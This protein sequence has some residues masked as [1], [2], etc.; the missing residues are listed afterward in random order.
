MEYTEDTIIYF[1]KHKKKKIKDIPQD[2]L[3]GLWSAREALSDKCMVAYLRKIFDENIDPDAPYTPDSKMTFGKYKK[4]KIRDVPFEYLKNFQNSPRSCT[5]RKLLEY[6]QDNHPTKSLQLYLDQPV[7]EPEPE[8]VPLKDDVTC[9][10]DT[11]MRFGIHEGKRIGDVPPDYLFDLYAKPKRCPSKKLLSYITRNLRSIIQQKNEAKPIV[12]SEVPKSKKPEKAV[13]TEQT[14]SVEYTSSTV[15]HFGQHKRKAIA[16]IPGDYLLKLHANPKSCPDQ[17]LIAYIAGNLNAI[18]DKKEV[19]EV[20][21]A[22]NIKVDKCN[23]HPHPNQDSAE[24]WISI[25]E[26]RCGKSGFLWSYLCDRCDCW[27]ITGI[28]RHTWK[29]TG[30]QIRREIEKRLGANQRKQNK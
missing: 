14:H 25:V 23:K 13:K 16:Q 18:K 27:H 3:Q 7:I 2:Y 5:D 20:L 30:K 8:V 21:V 1:G 4:K 29:K 6:L 19:R 12:V 28:S 15:I 22:C 24:K 11:I 26:T 9:T 10:K 17:K